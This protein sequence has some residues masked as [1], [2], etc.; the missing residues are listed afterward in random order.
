VFAGRAAAD[1]DHVVVGVHL[2]LQT[3]GVWTYGLVL[4]RRSRPWVTGLDARDRTRDP[5][6][7]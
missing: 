3:V 4:G 1:H 7:R 5:R 6:A 2:G